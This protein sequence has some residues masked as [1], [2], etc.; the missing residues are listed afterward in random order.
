M[1]LSVGRLGSTSASS[2]LSMQAQS[3]SLNNQS[4]VSAVYE[5][6]I[7]QTG[8]EASIGGV[9]PVQYPNAQLVANRV[10]QIQESQRM[11][12]AYNDIA[13]GLSGEIAFYNETSLGGQYNSIGTKVDAFA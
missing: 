4:A 8:M 2:I 7:Q 6:S 3:F 11:E 1:A 5:E 12:Q 10:S 13:A 9:H